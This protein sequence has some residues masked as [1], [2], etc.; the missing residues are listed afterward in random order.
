VSEPIGHG[1]LKSEIIFK[2]KER[3]ERLRAQRK[4][5]KRTRYFMNTEV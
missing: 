3:E 2:K 5:A 1:Q 4:R